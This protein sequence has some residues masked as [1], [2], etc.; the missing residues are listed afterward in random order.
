MGA[1][2][3]DFDLKLF[4]Q[5]FETEDDL[6][7]Y[8]QAQALERAFGRVQNYVADLAQCGA[9]LAR[10]PLAP[11]TE[12]AS[13]AQRAFQ[14]LRDGGV[15]DKNL[16]RRLIQAQ[17]ARSRVEHSYIE[18]PAGDVHRAAALVHETAG[19]FIGPYADWIADYLVE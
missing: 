11:L 14:A 3:D 16:C 6:D 10:L 12:N 2:G 1:F 8:N 7:S 17:N 4:K 19:L 13:R 18:V 9:K 5:A 15:I